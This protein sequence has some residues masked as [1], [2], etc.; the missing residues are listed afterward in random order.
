M[1]KTTSIPPAALAMLALGSFAVLAAAPDAMA[2]SNKNANNA[3][4]ATARD[5]RNACGNEVRDE[6]WIAAGNCDNLSDPAERSP[7][8]HEARDA[9]RESGRDCREQYD[10]RQSLCGAVGQAP[11]APAYD[12]ADFVDPLAVGGPLV[13]PNPY[14]PLVPGTRS[15]FDNDFDGETIVVS[16]THQ[17]IEVDGVTC[18]LVRDVVTNKVSGELI[19]D[20]DDY[21][22]QDLQG[23]VWYFGEVSREYE[24][25]FLTSLDGSWRAG[26]DDAHA[27]LLMKAAPQVG[28]V[29]RQE[30]MLGEAEDVAEVLDLVGSATAPFASCTGTCLVTKEYTPKSPGAVEHK[31]YMPGLGEI[32]VFNPET[33]SREVLVSVE[34]F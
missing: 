12:A 5:A 30:F 28:D 27:G 11:Y 7:C 29:Y 9:L 4:S 21:F 3:C 15:T 25:G 23:N 13:Q 6:F 32:L 33:S 16:V 22:A 17:T 18:I 10:A 26:V 20:T 1:T 24:D 8:L 31:Y 19:E 2:A 14:L 34:T